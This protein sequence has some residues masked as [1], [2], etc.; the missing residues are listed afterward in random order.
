[1]KMK[2]QS[3][4]NKKQQTHLSFRQKWAHNPELALMQTLDRD[5]SFQRWILDRNDFKDAE[6]AANQLKGYSR[7]LDAGCGNGRVT[8]LL[9]SLLPEAKIVGIDIIDL[10]IPKKNTEQFPN[11]KFNYAD[12]KS[13]QNTREKWEN[14]NL[15]ISKESS[16]QGVQ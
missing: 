15:C 4:K 10:D 14:R 3:Q 2:K 1:M 7:I 12:Q 11:V 16:S 8:A 13:G 9:A 5:S 6:D